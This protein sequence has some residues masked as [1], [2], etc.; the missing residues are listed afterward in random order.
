M[1]PKKWKLLSKKDVS[2]SKWFPIEERIYELPNGKI[3]DDFTVS[4]LSDVSLII[5]VTKDKKIILV[6]QYKPGVDEVILQFPGGRLEEN[7]KNFDELAQHELEEEVGVKV[8]LNQLTQFAKF[9]GFSTKASEI[10]Y[11]YIAK[12][13]EFNSKQHFDPTEEIEVITVTPKEMDRL[14]ESNQIWCA[15]T[16]AGWELAKKKFADYLGY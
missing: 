11:F 6:N 2:P 15:Q 10:V 3:V 4:T 12:D 9:S 7:H 13:C 14:V 8:E 16:V 1:K 5:P